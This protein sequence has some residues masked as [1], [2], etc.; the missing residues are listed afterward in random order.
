MVLRRIRFTCCGKVSGSCGGRSM[1]CLR[2]A[3]SL[4]KAFIRLNSESKK[5]VFLSAPRRLLPR[6]QTRLIHLSRQDALHSHG[7][8]MNDRRRERRQQS[9]QRRPE[10]A[11]GQIVPLGNL[12][13]VKFDFTFTSRLVSGLMTLNWDT[14]GREGVDC[15][16]LI[17]EIS[18]GEA[19]PRL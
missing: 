8:I 14:R 5:R 19:P 13:L 16:L 4:N 15:C 11:L 12:R 2:L 6:S 3:S 10:A 7:V 18:S 1:S 9:G 17:G